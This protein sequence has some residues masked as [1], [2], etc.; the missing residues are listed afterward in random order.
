LVCDIPFA[1]CVVTGNVEH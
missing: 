1:E